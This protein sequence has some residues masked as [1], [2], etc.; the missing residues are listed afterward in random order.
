MPDRKPKPDRATPHKDKL[1][2]TCRRPH[3]KRP[4]PSAATLKHP[5]PLVIT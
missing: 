5:A 4:Y 3:R 1:C 2:K